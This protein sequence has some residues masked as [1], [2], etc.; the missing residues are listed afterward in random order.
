MF[1]RFVKESVYVIYLCVL[2]YFFKFY[3]AGSSYIYNQMVLILHVELLD[4]IIFVNH[5][6]NNSIHKFVNHVSARECVCFCMYA[7][8]YFMLH[9]YF[10]FF[11]SAK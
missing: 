11:K 9:V 5:K 1:C 10:I 7:R 2:Q 3:K 8:K 4:I 6:T